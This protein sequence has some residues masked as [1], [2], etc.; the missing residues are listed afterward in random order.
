MPASVETLCVSPERVPEMWPHVERWIERA[1]R[2]CGDWTIK[3]IKDDVFSGEM[4]LWV[5]T[6]DGDLKAAA[7][8]Q[9]TIVPRG[10]V[11]TVIACGGSAAGS[12]KAALLPIEGY[13]NETACV[14]MRIRGRIA[15]AE[16]FD[17][18]DLEWVALE[19][20]LN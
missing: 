8:T 9:L 5:L 16:I 2:R 19:K 4:L 13:A 6:S 20:R 15:W 12:W 14:A 17:D 10:K 11:C 1:V 7:I 18:Y 3:A